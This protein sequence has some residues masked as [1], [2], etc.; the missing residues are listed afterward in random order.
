MWNFSRGGK[1]TED[2][3]ALGMSELS[4]EMVPC[5]WTIVEEGGGGED[6]N[7]MMRKEISVSL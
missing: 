6:K 2:E 3:S 5:A 1:H 7:K 4:F